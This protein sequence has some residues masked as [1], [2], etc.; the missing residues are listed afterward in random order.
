[1]ADG[2]AEIHAAFIGKA[3]QKNELEHDSEKIADASDKD[4]RIKVSSVG[5]PAARGN[6]YRIATNLEPC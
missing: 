6:L 3:A 4:A 1:M 2:R 5:L